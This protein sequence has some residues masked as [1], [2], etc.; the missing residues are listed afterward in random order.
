MLLRLFLLAFL[1]LLPGT[2]CA[3]DQNIETLNSIFQ[4]IVASPSSYSILTALY[5]FEPGGEIKVEKS[6]GDYPYTVTLPPVRLEYPGGMSMDFGSLSV[7]A[8]P[9]KPS[10]QW[11]MTMTIP[12]PL[13]LV[14]DGGR[15]ILRV[16]IGVQDI[17]ARWSGDSQFFT[18]MSAAYKDVQLT[19]E[20][21]AFVANIANSSV[22]YDL[23]KGD[24]ATWSGPFDFDLEK[25]AVTFGNTGAGL[26]IGQMKGSSVLDAYNAAAQSKYQEALSVFSRA[27][28]DAPAPG[29]D[30]ADSLMQDIKAFQGALFDFVMN[31]GHGFTSTYSFSDTLVQI[32]PGALGQGHNIHLDEI[33]SEA[34]V[35]NTHTD[36]AVISL[37]SRY[38]GLEAKTLMEDKAVFFPEAAGLSVTVK[39]FPFQT[40]LSTGQKTLQS[41][42]DNP[43]MKELAGMSFMMQIP[44]LLLQAGTSI[45][46][47]NTF[48]ENTTYKADIA[49]HIKALPGAPHGVGT[50]LKSTIS[51]LDTVLAAAEKEA[52]SGKN[53]RSFQKLADALTKIKALARP[54]TPENG[55]TVYT[56]EFTMDQRG[57]ILL[58][59][60]NIRTLNL[61]PGAAGALPF[62]KGKVQ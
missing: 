29:T 59:G 15:E 2:G 19:G 50:H 62:S 11:D 14:D 3:R 28:A 49:G 56:L 47:K 35:E 12:S 30:A 61:Q 45:L 18:A 53:A 4:N 41:V 27:V 23:T 36:K 20:D 34:L 6:G 1:L 25:I 13:S 33:V 9:L 38:S 31:W 22:R 37:K 5:V 40:L 39:D 48:I 46:I 55:E 8:R 42:Q 57:Q 17:S 60:Q 10:G 51:G 21:A 32:P 58:N 7:R 54:E 26:T 16:D 44:A 43:G 52:A 24:D